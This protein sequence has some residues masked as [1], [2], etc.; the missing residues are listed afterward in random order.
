MLMMAKTQHLS[1]LKKLYHTCFGGQPIE[2]ERFFALRYRP[3]D[4]FLFGQEDRPWSA[5]YAFSLEV[6]L[7]GFKRIPAVYVYGVGTM[8]AQRN[9]GYNRQV[10]EYLWQEV[11][12]RGAQVALLVPAEE[13]L[14]NFYRHQDYQVVSWVREGLGKAFVLDGKEAT[15]LRL[16]RISPI[17]YLGLREERLI[18][19]PHAR[20]DQRQIVYQGVVADA[21]GGGL[22]AF[23]Q[24][25]RAVGCAV[26]EIYEEKMYIKEL[27]LPDELISEGVSI[28]AVHWPALEIILRMPANT[29]MKQIFSEEIC[30]V[31][32]FAMAKSDNPQLLKQL[33]GCYFGLA[34]D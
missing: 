31:R 17:R 10:M 6:V 29:N 2:V 4:C 7:T 24:A 3:E 26:V 16:T 18:G 1:G 25:S 28:L 20:W 22:F 12:R 9:K 19:S 13:S 23:Y 15:K 27:L 34:L 8:P 14:F 30:P 11:R 5:A 33:Q 21:C 32:P